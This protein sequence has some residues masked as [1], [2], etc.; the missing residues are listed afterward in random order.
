[1][2]ITLW[3]I[4]DIYNDVNHMEYLIDSYSDI[5][6]LPTSNTKGTG[7]YAHLGICAIGSLAIVPNSDVYILNNS[8]N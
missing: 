2:A 5:S 6:N 7:S 8:N 4:R 1:M 3:K